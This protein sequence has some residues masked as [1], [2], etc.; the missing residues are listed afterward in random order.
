MEDRRPSIQPFL[1][2]LDAPED[3]ADLPAEAIEHAA[4]TEPPPPIPIG[5]P[6]LG[7][8]HGDPSSLRQQR[9]GIV[10]PEGQLGDALLG[11]TQLLIQQRR[12]QQGAE[13][14]VYRAPPALSAVA[15]HEW[16]Q[17]W[18]EDE[19]VSERE[20]PRYLLLLGDFDALSIELQQVLGLRAR[21]GRLAFPSLDGYEAYSRKVL[22]WETDSAAEPE[23]VLVSSRDGTTATE[24]GYLHLMQPCLTQFEREA[25]ALRASHLGLDPFK[26]EQAP[27]TKEELLSAAG[28]TPKVF[29]SM[30]HG[31]SVSRRDVLEQCRRQGALCLPGKCYLEAEDVR[32]RPFLSGG[33]WLF[34]ACFSAGTPA[35][36]VYEHWF[37]Q[38][39]AQG[40]YTRTART[41]LDT[42]APSP[43]VAALPQA[44]LA[45]PEGPLAVIGHVDILWTYSFSPAGSPCGSR[46][47]PFVETVLALCQGIRAGQ[48][49]FSLTEKF[50]R[51]QSLLV[52]L[53]EQERERGGMGD[54]QALTHLWLQRHDLLGF[55]LLGDPAVRL[56]LPKERQA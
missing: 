26:A 42:L 19:S 24:R 50:K 15:A 4:R 29:F 22:R 40:C 36:S 31:A 17:A 9:W 37:R 43:F 3:W 34:F 48:A 25:S 38:L 23:L 56:P 8:P 30:S 18:Y 51:V 46:V 6:L 13:P 44:A 20:R 11:A 41:L 28:K 12:E 14:R 45:N 54:L 55:I 2:P 39:F 10:V 53:L 32:N 5:P 21:T 1:M 35:R 27:L 47:A 7:A 52:D 16:C 33:I 49:L